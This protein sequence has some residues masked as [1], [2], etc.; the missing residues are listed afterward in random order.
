M[1]EHN[2]LVLIRSHV[3]DKQEGPGNIVQ[4]TVSIPADHI[5]DVLE[6]LHDILPPLPP[7]DIWLVAPSQIQSDCISHNKNSQLDPS[8]ASAYLKLILPLLFELFSNTVHISVRTKITGCVCKIVQYST[9]ASALNNVLLESKAFGKFVVELLSFSEAALVLEKSKDQ[10]H[11]LTLVLAGLILITLNIDKE[12]FQTLFIREGVAEEVNKIF[13]L[14][15]KIEEDKEPPSE[16]IKVVEKTLE[17]PERLTSME[18]QS[19]AENESEYEIAMT[20][21]VQRLMNLMG[22]FRSPEHDE[23]LMIGLTTESYSQDACFQRIYCLSSSLNVKFGLLSRKEAPLQKCVEALNQAV[24]EIQQRECLKDIANVLTA[25]GGLTCF[26]LANSGLIET[27][28][29][30]LTSPST[31]EEVS[32]LV[33]P[34]I[35]KETPWLTDV[36]SRVLSFI[37]VFLSTE[38]GAFESLIFSLMESISRSEKFQISNGSPSSISILERL[39][40]MSSSGLSYFQYH[41]S[42]PVAQFGRQIKLMVTAE[43]PSSLPS[44]LHTFQISIQAVASYHSLEL[45]IKS[46]IDNP[47]SSIPLDL[48]NNVTIEI[49]K[50]NDEYDLHEFSPLQAPSFAEVASAGT[51]FGIKFFLNGK[52]VPTNSTIFGSLFEYG[53]GDSNNSSDIWSKT[54]KLTYMKDFSPVTE[55]IAVKPFHPLIDCETWNIFYSTIPSNPLILPQVGLSLFL[56]KILYQINMNASNCQGLSNTT[57]F[58]KPDNLFLHHKLTSKINRQLDEPLIVVSQVLPKWCVEIVTSYSFLIP[59]RTR[60]AY[61][62]GTAFGHSRSILQVYRPSQSQEA[63]NTFSRIP[64]LKIRVSRENPIETMYHIMAMERHRES[65][66]EVEF[67]DEVL[68]FKKRSVQAWDLRSNFSR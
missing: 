58:K 12:V 49:I 42:N 35:K 8:V 63:D 47:N 68:C 50:H 59:F 1:N 38:S 61:L 53:P 20:Q 60:I 16:V 26:E 62:K 6:L 56:T 13:A 31:K 3:T 28:V 7:S 64:R 24:T 43:D 36:S 25:N 45:Y 37:L 19:S 4:F 52:P 41:L 11:I 14:L 66:I 27:F 9:N 55:S 15:Q 17:S 29:D 65:L 67:Y 33:I 57:I 10:N 23:N 34:T 21:Q 30:F 54:H 18:P 51:K 32:R 39:G 2:L 46:R 40:L 48:K 22:K 44:H 5:L